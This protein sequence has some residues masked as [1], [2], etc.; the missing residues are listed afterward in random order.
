MEEQLL[1]IGEVMKRF[2]EKIQDLQLQNMPGMPP[3]VREG[4]LW[5]TTLVVSRI[6]KF[7]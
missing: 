3:E 1:N 2:R 7:E 5:M 6:N 4:R